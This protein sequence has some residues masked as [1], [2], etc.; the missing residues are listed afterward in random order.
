M[1]VRATADW[2]RL[3]CRMMLLLLLLVLDLLLDLLLLL[4]LWGAVDSVRRSGLGGVPVVGVVAFAA[5][6]VE[7]L[8]AACLLGLTLLLLLL[9]VVATVV[10]VIVGVVT[11][12]VGGD[13]GGTGADWR[14]AADVVTAAGL[15]LVALAAAAAVAVAL[16]C[17]RARTLRMVANMRLLSFT[18]KGC[19]CCCPVDDM[20]EGLDLVFANGGCW[21]S[22]VDP[23]RSQLA[24]CS[25]VRCTQV[26]R[27]QG[28]RSDLTA[29]TNTLPSACPFLCLER[30]GAR[31]REAVCN[32]CAQDVT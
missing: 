16:E 5:G 24:G 21:L 27:R 7:P 23:K 18:G 25:L 32:V 26:L 2:R 4:L 14:G 20:V 30:D 11:S 19:C 28:N 10:V 3:C 29:P 31:E 9:I 17:R 12:Q 6:I 15:W 13:G 1:N 22:H 8:V